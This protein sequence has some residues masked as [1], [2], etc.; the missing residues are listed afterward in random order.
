M[1]FPIQYLLALRRQRL[2]IKGKHIPMPIQITWIG[3]V[4][5]DENMLTTIKKHLTLILTMVLL[6]LLFCVRTETF[7][8]V[9]VIISIVA[10][11]VVWLLD[12]IFLKEGKNQNYM[13][14]I[15]TI[16]II[17]IFLYLLC[18]SNPLFAKYYQTFFAF[19]AFLSSLS[20][21]TIVFSK[22]INKN[23]LIILMVI[24][25]LTG[26]SYIYYL[27]QSTEITIGIVGIILYLL[28]YFFLY[29]TVSFYFYKFLLFAIG[30]LNILWLVL[31]SY[32][33]TPLIGYSWFDYLQII[34]L[35]FVNYASCIILIS[36]CIWIQENKFHLDSNL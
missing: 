10:I 36:L 9:N 20:L 32:N 16:P 34:F 7:H 8:N 3:M 27:S 18:G 23:N 22:R 15:K 30:L 26:A 14:L 11:F 35:F 24:F 13:L 12:Y 17:S 5:G 6:I 28:H 1:A 29:Y 25:I 4:F 33:G 21:S 2:V 19:V 31:A